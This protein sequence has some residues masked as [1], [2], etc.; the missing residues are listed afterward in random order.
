MSQSVLIITGLFFVIGI[1]VGV[2]AVF[3]LS[4]IK[5]E[6]RGPAASW[7]EYEPGEPEQPPDPDEDQPT[8]WHARDDE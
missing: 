3:A 5:A 1:T 4:G 7:P 6:R 2:I 8:W